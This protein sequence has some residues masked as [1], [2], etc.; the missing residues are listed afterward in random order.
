M[1]RQGP[2]VR[3]RTSVSQIVAAPEGK[4]A[5]YISVIVTSSHVGPGGL[6]AENLFLS[7]WKTSIQHWEGVR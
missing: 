1:T 5:N 3:P 4:Y 2:L 7:P 6:V